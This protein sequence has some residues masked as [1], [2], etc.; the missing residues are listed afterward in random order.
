MTNERQIT[1]TEFFANGGYRNQMQYSTGD[2]KHG[3]LKYWTRAAR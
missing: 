3:N 2:A 1:E